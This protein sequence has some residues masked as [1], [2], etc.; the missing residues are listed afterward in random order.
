M[1]MKLVLGAGAALC[2]TAGAALA[3]ES[4]S[5]TDGGFA[6]RYDDLDLQSAA[7]QEELSARLDSAI[8]QACRAHNPQRPSQV[9]VCRRD[10]AEYVAQHAA[11]EVRTALATQ[12]RRRA[13]GTLLSSR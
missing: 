12:Q 9:S 11:P 4:A 2:L 6:V 13:S 5:D 1:N 7:G 8:N 10:V 3:D